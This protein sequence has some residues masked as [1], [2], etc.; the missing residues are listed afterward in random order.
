MALS[1]WIVVIKGWLL[2]SRD[3]SDYLRA[4]EQMQWIW[5]N[6]EMEGFLMMIFLSDKFSFCDSLSSLSLFKALISDSFFSCD[7]SSS[8]LRSRYRISFTSSLLF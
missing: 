4:V 2:T 5:E 3:V 8:I 6:W 1:Y 7:S